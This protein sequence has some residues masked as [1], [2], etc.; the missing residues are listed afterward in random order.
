M[1]ID[2]TQHRARIGL[3]VLYQ[4]EVLVVQTVNVSPGLFSHDGYVC[5]HGAASCG[6]R[7]VRPGGNTGWTFVT[8]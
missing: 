5:T 4:G 6:Q 2:A 7:G 3:F 1:P 8:D